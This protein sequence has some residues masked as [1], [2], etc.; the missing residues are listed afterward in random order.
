MGRGR[1]E[2]VVKRVNEWIR[3]I[4]PVESVNDEEEV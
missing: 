4:P 3:T 1:A 2:D